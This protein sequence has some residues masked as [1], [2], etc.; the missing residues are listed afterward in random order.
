A[1]DIGVLAIFS[2]YLAWRFSHTGFEMNAAIFWAIVAATTATRLINPSELHRDAL[3]WG[4]FTW[5][6]ALGIMAPLAGLPFL[7]LDGA[8]LLSFM[9]WAGHVLFGYV[10]VVI[11]ERLETRA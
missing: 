10:A 8:L 9:S 2:A 3:S 7:L 1:L 6:N 4:S 11:F 5:F